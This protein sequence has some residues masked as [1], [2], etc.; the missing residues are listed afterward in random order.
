MPR[1]F[2]QSAGSVETERST[3]GFRQRLIRKDDGA[4]SSITRLK[5]YDASAHWHEKTHE[6]YY[7]LSGTGK[8]VI[9][10]EDVPVRDGDC[11]WIHPGAVHHA[12]GDLESLIVAS[13]AYDPQD[14]FMQC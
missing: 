11:V 14:T 1:Y 9:D 10:G 12:E 6:F 5:I 3:C 4:P 13:P 7:V 8:L 2:K